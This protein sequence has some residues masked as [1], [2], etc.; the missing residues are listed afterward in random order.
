MDFKMDFKRRY[1]NV[2]YPWYEFFSVF[3]IF[4][5]FDIPEKIVS[6]NNE[7]QGPT[8]R[9]YVYFNNVEQISLALVI[10]LI[11][12]ALKMEADLETLSIRYFRT[13]ISRE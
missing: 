10:I 7:R 13:E 11:R 9:E 4:L 3:H 8:Y 1:E 6:N 12:I 5:E 2:Q